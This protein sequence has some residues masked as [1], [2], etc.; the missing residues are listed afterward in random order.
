MNKYKSLLY[1]FIPVLLFV[2]NTTF[3]AQDDVNKYQKELEMRKKQNRNNGNNSQNTNKINNNNQDIDVSSFWTE[4]FALSLG[5]EMAY[6]NSRSTV[7]T[8][9]IRYSTSYK[10]LWDI[11]FSIQGSYGE[12]LDTSSNKIA[13]DRSDHTLNF[14]LDRWF[15]RKLI[16]ANYNTTLT[17]NEFSNI[18]LR[19]SNGLAFKIRPV[20]IWWLQLTLSISPAVE[21]TRT[22]DLITRKTE[23]RIIYQAEMNIN[24]DKKQSAVITTNYT[25]TPKFIDY[26]DN[27]FNLTAGLNVR[28]IKIFKLSV[29]FTYDFVSQPPNSYTGV[30]K[31][32]YRISTKLGINL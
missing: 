25:F 18:F 1:I 21:Y 4:S 3:Y 31:S 14:V 19:W 17:T 28:F 27:R 16:A 26:S 2:F 22:Y 15:L 5:I 8:Y 7:G 32:D 6:G 23:W 29:N 30:K 24:L 20:N 13:K 9:E 12:S 11:N 10:E